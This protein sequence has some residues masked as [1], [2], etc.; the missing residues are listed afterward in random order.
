[1]KGF[2]FWLLSLMIVAA[3]IVLA[4]W[5][6]ALRRRS[7]AFVSKADQY[8]RHI[9]ELT[10]LFPG[11]I[12]YDEIILPIGSSLTKTPQVSERQLRHLEDFYRYVLTENDTAEL[13]HGPK[14]NMPDRCSACYGSGMRCI[15]ISSTDGRLPGHG[16]RWTLTRPCPHL[17][18]CLPWPVSG[19][20]MVNCERKSLNTCRLSLIV[21]LS[22]SRHSQRDNRPGQMLSVL[23]YVERIV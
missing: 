6:Y 1:M 5:G 22:E 10:F 20:G 9:F 13:A 3:M 11:S 21:R 4:A 18:L 2:R 8:D 14:A 23:R 17:I 19:G 15:C 12:H 16:S 7:A